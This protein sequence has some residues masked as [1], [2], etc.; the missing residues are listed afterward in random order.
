[1]LS[2][3]TIC[4]IIKLVLGDTKIPFVLKNEVQAI[5]SALEGEISVNVPKLHEVPNLMVQTSAVSVSN[6]VSPATMAK[7]EA[8]DFVLRLLIQYMHKGEKAKGLAI[9]TVRCKAV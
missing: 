7:A 6:H 9:S 2:Y 4:N 1:M 3:A 5:S 8:K